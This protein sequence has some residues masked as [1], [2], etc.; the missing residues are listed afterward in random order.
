MSCRLQSFQSH[1]MS[2]TGLIFLIRRN[3]CNFV[4]DRY[5]GAARRQ[6]S[7]VMVTPSVPPQRLPVNLVRSGRK[8][9]QREH[10]VPGCGWWGCLHNVPKDPLSRNL[11]KNSSCPAAMVPVQSGFLSFLIFGGIIKR[12]LAPASYCVISGLPPIYSRIMSSISPDIF[13]R[14]KVFRILC[15]GTLGSLRT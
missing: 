2:L 4:S 12:S 15:T 1:R 3:G 5:N 7:V 10:C 8:Q 11:I 14:T 9:P 6:V 13:I